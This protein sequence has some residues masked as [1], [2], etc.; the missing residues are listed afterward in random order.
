MSCYLIFML[1]I[2]LTTSNRTYLQVHLRISGLLELKKRV[3]YWDMKCN[4]VK[5]FLKEH[6]SPIFSCELCSWI[7]SKNAGGCKEESVF[8][9]STLLQEWFHPILHYCVANCQNDR[10]FAL[11]LWYFL[12]LISLQ[13]FLQV[14]SRSG[15][16]NTN[17]KVRPNWCLNLELVGWFL[18]LR[19]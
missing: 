9:I 8:L 10:K 15:L 18:F 16:C 14:S 5:L 12:F 11:F 4:G 19:T 17:L 3:Q 2:R 13:V 6:V 1:Q 7:S